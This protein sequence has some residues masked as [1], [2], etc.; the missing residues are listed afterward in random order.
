M[1]RLKPGQ[2]PQPKYQAKKL[3]EP[4][5]ENLWASRI[6]TIFGVNRSTI[7]R[8]RNPRTMLDQWDADHYAIKIGKHP[9]EISSDWFDIDITD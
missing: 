9:S 6:A 2:R 1:P 8:W 3:L 7:Q 5:G 4:Y